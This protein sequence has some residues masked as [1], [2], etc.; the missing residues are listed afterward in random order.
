MMIAL[1]ELPHFLDLALS[2]ALFLLLLG[3][4]L[5]ISGPWAPNPRTLLTH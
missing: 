1:L 3:V 2:G 5:S 4:Q